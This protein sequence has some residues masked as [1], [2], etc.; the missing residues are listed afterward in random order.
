MGTSDNFR[1]AC[2]SPVFIELRVNHEFADS[3]LTDLSQS[4]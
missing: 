2:W 4:G 1:F 3:R